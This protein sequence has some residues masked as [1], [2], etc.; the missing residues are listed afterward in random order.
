M[1]DNK[2]LSVTIKQ[3]QETAPFQFPLTVELTYSSGTKK[4]VN[5]DVS[6]TQQIFMLPIDGTVESIVIDPDTDL[7][8]DK[9]IDFKKE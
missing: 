3:L 5:L 9:W 8:L 6:K 7:L 1:A 4:R 2:F